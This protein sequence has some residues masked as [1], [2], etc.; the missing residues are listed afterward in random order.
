[1]RREETIRKLQSLHALLKE[2][3]VERLRL[4]GSVARDEA[5]SRSDVD[6]IVDLSEK[7]DL[8]DF[9]ALQ[10]DL[11]DALGTRVDLASAKSLRPELREAILAEAIDV[12]AA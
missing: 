7:R 2:H 4:F 11:S 12:K 3:G 6:L 5:T 8:L 1:M 9:V 10:Q